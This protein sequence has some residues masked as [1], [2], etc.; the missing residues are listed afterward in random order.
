MPRRDDRPVAR[1]RLPSVD[2]HR[3]STR[4]R[5][6]RAPAWIAGY[7]ST[8]SSFPTGRRSTTRPTHRVADPRRGGMANETVLVDLGPAAPAWW[9]ACRRSKP[10]FPDYDLAPQAV[11]QNA[12]AASG[13]PAPAPAV[14]VTDP[15]YLGSQFL[16][17]P[18]VPGDVPGPAPM[19]DPYVRDAGPAL[20]RLMHDGLIDVLA[21]VHAVPWRGTGLGG[22]AAGNGAARRGRPL[23]GLR[24][25]VVGGRSVARAGRGARVVRPSST[26][27]AGAGRALGRRAPGQPRLR[28]GAPGT[29]VLDWDL[30]ASGRPRWTSAGISGS[31]S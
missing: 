15:G 10:T 25:L 5:R 29:R 3:G 22:T 26:G 31:S 8:R 24:G 12:A 28:P 13:V 4:R 1:R 20:Q 30:A 27:G 6:T 17:M 9:C 18:R 16:V 21:E 23:D 11:V 7:P 2:G 14:V 19:L